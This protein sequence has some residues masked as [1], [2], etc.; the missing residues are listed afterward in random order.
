[1]KIQV[2][3]FIDLCLAQ[4]FVFRLQTKKLI[5]ELSIGRQILPV[6]QTFIL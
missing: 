2:K 4:T 1:M 5:L 6:A 3:N